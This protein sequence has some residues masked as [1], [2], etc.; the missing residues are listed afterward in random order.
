MNPHIRSALAPVLVGKSLYIDVVV[1]P[2][3]AGL[4]ALTRSFR[5]FVAGQVFDIVLLSEK[6]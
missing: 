6:N 4:S 2:R 1:Y 3:T 5:M